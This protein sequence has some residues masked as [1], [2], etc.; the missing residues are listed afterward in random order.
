VGCY[1]TVCSYELTEVLPSGERCGTRM[2][3]LGQP[4]GLLDA[5]SQ[6]VLWDVGTYTID[7]PWKG[8]DSDSEDE[9]RKKR[10]RRDHGVEEE[11]DPLVANLKI[12]RFHSPLTLSALMHGGTGMKPKL[13]TPWRSHS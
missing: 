8:D 2:C 10:R 12:S 13:A 7:Y 11:D 6:A 3:C 5:Y 1:L 9:K 4:T